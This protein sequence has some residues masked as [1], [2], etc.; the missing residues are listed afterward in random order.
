[1]VE[2]SRF[3]ARFGVR[4][5]ELKNQKAFV[6]RAGKDYADFERQYQNGQITETEVAKRALQF[7]ATDPRGFAYRKL[8]A[9]IGQLDPGGEILTTTLQQLSKNP[10]AAEDF[11]KS[12]AAGKFSKMKGKDLARMAAAESGPGYDY[13]SLKGSVAARREM[14]RYVITDPKA[15]SGLDTGQIE[16]GI[17][18][19]GG[20]TTADGRNFLKEVGKISPSFAV[21]YNSN[22]TRNPELRKEAEEG[23][24]RAYTTDPAHPVR[25]ANDFQLKTHMYGSFLKTGDM[26]DTANIKKD[27]WENSPEFK[28]ALKLYIAQLKSDGI[29]SPRTNYINRLGEAL[30]N[31]VGGDRKL[32]ILHTEILSSPTTT[33][34][35]PGGRVP[36]S[37]PTSPL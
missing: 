10:L 25:A 14:F 19:F 31:T 37:A 23:F 15:M 22:S 28:E 36:P 20:H 4:G 5:A 18:V 3:G 32:E 12:A 8:A 1:M 13:S 34:V 21:D 11:A 16:A 26:K 30:L 27:T 35:M 17:S 24:E 2:T 6:D 7:D 33:G 29:R 9:K